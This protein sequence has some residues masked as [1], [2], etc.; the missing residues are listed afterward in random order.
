M[1]TIIIK[2]TIIIIIIIILTIIARIIIKLTLIIT[3]IIKLTQS[4]LKFQS[5]NFLNR[6]D[7][8]SL[9]CGSTHAAKGICILFS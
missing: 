2:L 9:K 6:S 1:I 7:R 5:R 8:S 3:I 4:P